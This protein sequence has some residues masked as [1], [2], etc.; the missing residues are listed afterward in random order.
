MD[1]SADSTSENGPFAKLS[2]RGGAEVPDPAPAASD[3]GTLLCATRMR[4]GKDLQQIASLLHIRYNYLVAIEDGR[5]EDLPGQAYALGFVRAYAEHLGL[6][7]DEIV[8]RY[9]DENAGLRR[10]ASLDFPV[11]TPESGVPSGALL[12]VAVVMGMVV[13]GVWYS[14]AGA[15]RRAAD[16][17][18]EVPDRLANLLGTDRPA[19][20][21]VAATA[22]GPGVAVA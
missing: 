15:D 13:Y 9:K 18:Q 6:D 7:G 22:P 17:I 16:L 8:R 3:V 11:P 14:F 21:P 19:D 12:A 1:D 5:F 2:L 10:K 20:R 4:L